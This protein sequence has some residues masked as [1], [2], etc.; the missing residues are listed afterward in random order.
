MSA[1]PPSV[2]STIEAGGDLFLFAPYFWPCPVRG[3]GSTYLA[4]RA[5][6]DRSFNAF[7]WELGWYPPYW[8]LPTSML[9][10][11]GVGSV[12]NLCTENPAYASGT[13]PEKMVRVSRRAFEIGMPIREFV[14]WKVDEVLKTMREMPPG[15]VW[16]VA[17]GEYGGDLHHV[18]TMGWPGY[19]EG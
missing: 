19:A 18:R 10:K 17:H 2:L 15:A 7:Y 14:D 4:D 1:E 11:Y 16:W 6:G 13:P 3:Q 5:C 8:S 12:C 9:K